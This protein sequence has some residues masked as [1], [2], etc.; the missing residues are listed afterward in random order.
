MEGIGCLWSCSSWSNRA[1]SLQQRLE[2]SGTFILMGS[3]WAI[4]SFPVGPKLGFGNPLW[5][6]EHVWAGC[7]ES[8]HTLTPA[9]KQ[10]PKMWCQRRTGMGAQPQK[11]K[12][13]PSSAAGPWHASP[14]LL[15]PY[16]NHSANIFFL[17]IASPPQN[18][19]FCLAH[20][21]GVKF[22]FVFFFKETFTS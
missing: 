12:Q 1:Q 2:I 4:Q 21:Y 16:F 20:K 6:S 14:G 5:S 11:Q 17:S 8:Q 7:S 13:A 18:I 3:L 22:M 15:V 10:F 19:C 9:T